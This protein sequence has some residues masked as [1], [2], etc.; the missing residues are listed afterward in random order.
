MLCLDQVT[1]PR[2]NKTQ[3]AYDI[4]DDGWAMEGTAAWVEDVM[5]DD[6][7]DNYQFLMESAITYPDLPIDLIH[8][9][10][11]GL[12]YGGWLFFRFLTEYLGDGTNHEIDI[13]R[14]MW[15]RAAARDRGGD[16]AG[17]PLVVEANG[18]LRHHLVEDIALA[19][20]ALLARDTPA[21][22]ARYGDAIV[23]MDDAL[24]QVALDAGGRAHFEGR[25]PSRLY[26]H[27]FRSLA[28]AAS[29]TLHVRVIRGRDRHHII[30]AA[31]K[32]AKHRIDQTARAEDR[33]SR[34][35]LQNQSG[36]AAKAPGVVSAERSAAHTT[37]SDTRWS[38]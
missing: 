34:H 4:A 7:N 25:L 23:P 33:A 9:D 10:F 26:E 18:D 27:F 11:P 6:V 13:V 29:W 8:Q 36:Q 1:D 24:V 2:G 17:L 30:E 14:E 37:A 20:G 15:E 12:R 28:M 38:A 21:T 16:S 31:F 19:L 32:R 3:F 22:C 35:A 5:Y